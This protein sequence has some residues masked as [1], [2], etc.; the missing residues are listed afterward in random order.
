MRAYVLVAVNKNK[1]G[2]LKIFRL[3]IMLLDF[4]V[5]PMELWTVC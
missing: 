5:G 4:L 3:S 2:S 1:I